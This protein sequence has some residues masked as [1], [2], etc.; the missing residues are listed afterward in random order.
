MS[1]NTSNLLDTNIELQGYYY[2]T[3]F[4]NLMN[5]LLEFDG[6]KEVCI[7]CPSEEVYIYSLIF[8]IW[9]NN[10]CMVVTNVV[11]FVYEDSNFS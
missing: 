6:S 3:M 1:M 2:N 9:L 10:V 5:L 11:I 7:C 4:T 8:H